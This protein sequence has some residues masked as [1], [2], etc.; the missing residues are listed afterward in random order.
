MD[1]A[2][3][4]RAE[5]RRQTWTATISRTGEHRPVGLLPPALALASMWEIAVSSWTL[6]G[7]PLPEYDRSAM[8]GALRRPVP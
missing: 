6:G 3:A 2:A 1:S 7:R 5:R 8:P 4:K